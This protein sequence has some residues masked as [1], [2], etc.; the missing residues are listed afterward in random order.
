MR[1]LC[2]KVENLGSRFERT[3]IF[4]VEKEKKKKK[5]GRKKGGNI[6]GT[7]TNEKRYG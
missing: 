3:K 2:R 6:E 5:G 7:T 4:P 1:E